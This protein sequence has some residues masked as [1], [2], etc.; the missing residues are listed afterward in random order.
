MYYQTGTGTCFDFFSHS[1]NGTGTSYLYRF[2][3]KGVIGLEMLMC[4]LQYGLYLNKY[5]ESSIP[6]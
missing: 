6:V 4:L 1:K 3:F 5:F 2:K